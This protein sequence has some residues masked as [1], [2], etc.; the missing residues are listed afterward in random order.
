MSRRR[1]GAVGGRGQNLLWSRYLREARD[2]GLVWEL[3]KPEFLELTSKP[4]TY[5]AA[6]PGAYIGQISPDDLTY[7]GTYAYTGL[8]RVENDRGYCVDNVVPCCQQCNFAKRIHTRDEFL[9]WIKR[10]YE[11]Q[12]GGTA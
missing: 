10:V 4:C 6:P 11:K 3:T 8:D 1:K 9:S 7:H 5:C 2:R 12:F